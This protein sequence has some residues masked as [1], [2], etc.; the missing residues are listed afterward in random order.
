VNQYRV[1]AGLFIVVIFM[2]L[3]ITGFVLQS[4]EWQNSQ[5]RLGER[6]PLPALGY[7]SADGVRPCI[8]YFSRD[9]AGTMAIH[10]QAL[11]AFPPPFYLAISRQEAKNTYQ[12]K[13]DGGLSTSFTCRGETMPVGETLQLWVLSTEDDTALAEGKL[14]IVGLALATPEPAATPTRGPVFPR[15]PR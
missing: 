3:I 14:A 6:E 5:P 11:S 7:C 2:I 12:C 4:R 13:K 10:V 9:A 15:L 1:P 8:L